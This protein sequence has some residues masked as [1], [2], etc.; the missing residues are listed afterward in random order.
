M[1]QFVLH[2]LPQ[3]R[4]QTC[5]RVWENLSYLLSQTSL[6]FV[7]LGGDILVDHIDS[8]PTYSDFSLHFAKCKE[9]SR[10]VRIRAPCLSAQCLTELA[11]CA[12]RRDQSRGLCGAYVDDDGHQCYQMSICASLFSLELAKENSLSAKV[13]AKASIKHVVYFTWHDFEQ[14]DQTWTELRP[15]I[16]VITLFEKAFKHRWVSPDFV[17]AAMLKC[18]PI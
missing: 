13:F 6:C 1:W 12:M 16:Y 7:V 18:R 14:T 15:T 5:F 10:I 17:Q 3:E 4:N 8:H 9:V 11:D 2:L